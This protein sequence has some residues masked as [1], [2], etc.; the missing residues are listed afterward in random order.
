MALVAFLE[1]GLDEV[2]AGAGRDLA[3][4]LL[5]QFLVKLR[6]APQIARFQDRG[7]NCYVLLA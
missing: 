4:E 6:V 5:A 3:P 7:S 2:L 1:L